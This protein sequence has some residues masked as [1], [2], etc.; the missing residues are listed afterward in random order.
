M[1]GQQRGNS[2]IYLQDRYELQVLDSF[3]DTTLA[4]NEAGAIYLKRAPDSNPATAPET[5]QTYDITFRAARF[6]GT[7]KTDERPGHRGV[8]RRHRAQQRRRS[9]A[10]TGDGAAE[11]RDR[12]ADPAAGP[13]RRRRQRPL[14]QHLDRAARLSAAGG[15]RLSAAGGGRLDGRPPPGGVSEAGEGGAGQGLRQGPEAAGRLG[16]GGRA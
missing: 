11:G 8:E 6:D 14:P 16:V 1:T 15:G 5:W 4:D 10:P 9:T 12:R 13:R 2:G 7:T 3:G